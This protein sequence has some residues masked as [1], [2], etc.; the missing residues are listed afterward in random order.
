MAWDAIVVGAGINGLAAAV[1]LGSK[2]WK[3]LVL[4]QAAEPGGAVKTAE[5]TLPGFAHDVCA[6]NLSMFAGSAF[7]A[8]HKTKLDAAGL[9]LLPAAK[10]FASVLPGNTWLGVDSDAAK[11][12]GRIA[13]RNPRDAEAWGA[14]LAEFGQVAPHVFA[15]LGSPVPSFAALKALWRA[16]RALGTARCMELAKLMVSSPRAWL[17]AHFEDPGVHALMGAWGMHLDFGP[18][19]AGGAL[20]PYLE[21]MASQAFGMALGRGGVCT[22]V[23]AMVKVIEQQGGQVRCNASVE[24]IATEQGKAQGVVLQ[25]GERIAASRAVIANT[26][27][28]LLYGKLLSAESSAKRGDAKEQS[29]LP[30]PARLRSGPGTMMIHLAM[31]Q[32]PAW[33]ASTA[34]QEFAYV[35]LAPTL[36]QMARTYADAMAGLL[37]AEPVLVVGQPTSY[38]PARAPDGKHVLWLQ[39]RVLPTVVKGDAA[40]VIAPAHWDQIKEAYADR[41][42]ALLE[43]YAPGVSAQVLARKVHSPIDLERANPNLVDGDSLSGSHHLDQFFCFRPA[44]GHSRWRTPVQ[45]LYMVGA[46]TWPGAGTGAGSGY[47]L[48]R[49]LAGA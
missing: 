34:L 9:A 13:E 48:A 2:G 28:R 18:D 4:E 27:P 30:A 8:A 19:V 46:S 47:M 14:M 36:D 21:S 10:S 35:H 17:G 45:Q 3:V 39:V 12:M 7:Y 43:R 23:N 11:T 1:H 20:F 41:V 44:F 32:L 38:D 49:D 26:H 29:A 37:P 5:L 31:A 15:V 16:W 40:G 24:R 22:V 42:M 33:T 6:M 25:G